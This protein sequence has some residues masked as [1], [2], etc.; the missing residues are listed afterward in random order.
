MILVAGLRN[1]AGAAAA[2]TQTHERQRFGEHDGNGACTGPGG[3][4]YE[5]SRMYGYDLW[6]TRVSALQGGRGCS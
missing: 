1:S 3:S 6:S 4:G 5:L 2:G